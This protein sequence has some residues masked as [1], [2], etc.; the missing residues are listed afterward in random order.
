M[1]MVM[2]APKMKF[3]ASPTA[4]SPPDRSTAFPPAGKELHHPP[5]D[6]RGGR[7][8]RKA[9]PE[10]DLLL[11]PGRH[12][13][14]AEPCTRHRG[15]D[16][17]HQDRDVDLDDL[18]VNS[19]LN[20]GGERVSDVERAGN[21]AIGN[22]LREAKDGGRGG[23]RADAEGVEKVG[24]RTRSPAEKAWARRRR[25]PDRRAGRRRGPS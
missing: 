18:R 15:G 17:E 16:H 6:Q 12:H 9:H 1:P 5:H 24:H 19:G 23:E 11:G 8:Q 3:P 21:Q 10:L 7:E 20:E 2:S 22:H 4:S 13:A 25:W 14:G